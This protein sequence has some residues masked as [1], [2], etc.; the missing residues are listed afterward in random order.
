MQNSLDIDCEIKIGIWIQTVQWS[1]K[2]IIVEIDESGIKELKQM[3]I[4]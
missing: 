2:K 3:N 1:D 4:E